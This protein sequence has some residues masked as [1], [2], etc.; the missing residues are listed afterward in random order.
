VLDALAGRLEALTGQPPKELKPLQGGTIAEVFT[1]LMDGQKVLVK[2]DKA[3][4]LGPEAVMLR[5]LREHSALPVPEVLYS[6]SDILVLEFLPGNH[7]PIP[8]G[9]THIAELLAA[10][11]EIRGE[12]YGFA[13]DTMLGPWL[14]PNPPNTSWPD[15]FR[16][17]RLR[18]LAGLAFE[19][20]KLPAETFGRVEALAEG[21]ESHFSAPEAR[22]PHPS[23]IHGDLWSG[24]VLFQDG[25]VTGVLDPAIYFADA[26]MELAYIDL[27]DTFGPAF[28]TRYFELRPPRPGFEARFTLYAL[29]PLL[30]HTLFFGGKY[31]EMLEAR[32]RRLETHES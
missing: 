12:H 20:G 16:D 22:P 9:E 5:Y 29:Y 11:H 18:Y 31:L 13:H 15:F 26:E 3:G 19:A 2:W 30:A 10:L 14:Q 6:D 25:R 17:Q 32:L 24:N 4:K 7:Q 28:W 27:F 1:A 23:L 8:E 21:L